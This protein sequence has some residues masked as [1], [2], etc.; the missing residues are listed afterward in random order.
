MEEIHSFL[1]YL[2]VE[3]GVSRETLRG[4]RSDL[5][6]F[7][8]FLAETGFATA[9]GDET[10]F[11]CIDP[12]LIRAFMA[13]LQ[14]KGMA[15]SSIARKLAC[16]R[17]FFRYLVREGK[18]RGNPAKLVKSPKLPKRLPSYLDVDEAFQLLEAAD[19]QDPFDLRD[20]ALLELL[21]ASGIRVGELTAL[22]L[23]DLDLESGLL[24]VRGKGGRERIVPVGRKALKAL[25]AYL[26]QRGALAA[27]SLPAPCS[28]PL[29]PALFLNGRG[30]RLSARSVGTIVLKY[31]GKS[32]LGPKITP[33]GLRHSYATHLLG[34]G[35][36]LR[37]IQEL[38]G[39]RRLSTTQRYAHVSPE[40]LMEVYDKAHPRA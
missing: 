26:A 8:A 19:G 28:Q 23:Q 12:V 36:D 7:L 33:H 35:A 24:R 18:L 4:Y 2:Q 39:H 17:T 13:L 15:K 31:L 34:A 22:N 3:R 14:G 40:H 38:L 9:E 6:Q 10:D 25:R 21:Y 1:A 27:R 37:A 30:G 5:A 11:S 29:A 20:R 32:G 16:L